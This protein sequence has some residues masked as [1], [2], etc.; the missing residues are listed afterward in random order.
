MM[1]LLQAKNALN[2]N[3]SKE[4][5]K[6]SQNTQKKNAGMEEIKAMLVNMKEEMGIMEKRLTNWIK[7]KVGK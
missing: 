1:L 5:Y 4:T 6:S 2:F 7:W 3:A